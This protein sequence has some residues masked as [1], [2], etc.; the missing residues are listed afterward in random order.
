MLGY[1]GDPVATR[2][3]VDAEGWMHTG[4]LATL[5][6]DGYCRI[7]GRLKD[8]IIRAGE[9]V[10]PQEIEE[11]LHRHPKVAEACV[12][13]VPDTR[14]GEE[15]CA[16]IRLRE[17]ASATAREIRAFCR[18]RLANF[19]VPRYIKF[20]DAF[21]LTV[22]GKVQRFAMR[23]ETLA[24]LKTNALRRRPIRAAQ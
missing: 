23:E 18:D 11:A 12:F 21:P 10:A 9:N 6:A 2:E 19:K 13:G 5:D 16:W 4:D 17:P 24:E 3:A 15:I 8:I 22:T 7:V 1:W 14:F 20:V